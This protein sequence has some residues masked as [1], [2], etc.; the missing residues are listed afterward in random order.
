M[1]RAPQKIHVNRDDIGWFAAV[2][3]EGEGKE[4][5]PDFETDTHIEMG[6]ALANKVRGPIVV[7]SPLVGTADEPLIDELL[8]AYEEAVAYY[9][10]IARS[11]RA[12]RRNPVT[13]HF[14]GGGRGER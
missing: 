4:I 10:M 7:N 6:W 3:V 14:I 2:G 13:G 8:K 1:E 12:R 9:R 11:R 5:D